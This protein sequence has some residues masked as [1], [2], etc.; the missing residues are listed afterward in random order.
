MACRGLSQGRKPRSS[1][2]F[3]HP[4]AHGQSKPQAFRCNPGLSQKRHHMIGF[5][6]AFG[7]QPVI[8]DQRQNAPPARRHPI[9]RQQCQRQAMR[10]TGNRHGK[11]GRRAKGPK[12]RNGT[13]KFGATDRQGQRRKGLIPKSGSPALRAAAAI[14]GAFRLRARQVGEVGPQIIQR[15]TGFAP[16]AK[17]LEGIGQANHRLWRAATL[18]VAIEGFVISKGG[19]LE[20]PLAHQRIAQQQRCVL[21]PRPGAGTDR[22][23]RGGLSR[24]EIA[25]GQRG[26]AISNRLFSGSRGVGG[27]RAGRG[28][29]G[30][31]RRPR[32]RRARG[33]R[34]ASPFLQG[35]Q[36]EI[37]ITAQLFQFGTQLPEGTSIHVHDSNAELRYL[38]VPR[39]PAG[40][41]GWD[42][43][44]LEQLVTRDAMIG[45]TEA[46]QP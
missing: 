36:T 25:P 4:R 23:P 10:P 8:R 27:C 28:W 22:L 26:L 19:I 30:L 13:S 16:C 42:A 5:G 18:A 43:A 17:A 34:A 12:R 40:T 33:G 9:A 20:I 15:F 21:R 46:R 39:R 35:L 7:A 32:L 29:L 2:A 41:E 24:W 38:V 14:G 1:G 3:L 11:A 44:K 37:Q 6:A 31:R 45:V